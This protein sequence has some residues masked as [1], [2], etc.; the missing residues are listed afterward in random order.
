MAHIP[1]LIH[2][3][4]LLQNELPS[5]TKS[6]CL[7]GRNVEWCL[8]K[9]PWYFIHRLTVSKVGLKI[10]QE[11]CPLS[12]AMHCIHWCYPHIPHS[13]TPKLLDSK[14]PQPADQKNIQNPLC[15]SL[16]A[17]KA[18]SVTWGRLNTNL[19]HHWLHEEWATSDILLTSYVP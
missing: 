15:S 7:K 5:S 9:C 17:E 3:P 4:S 18:S 14:W 8:L 10:L 6:Y 2:R 11:S 1:G 16:F 12:E 13:P 19:S